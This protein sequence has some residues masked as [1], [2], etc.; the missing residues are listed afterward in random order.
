MGNVSD[1]G[2]S[3]EEQFSGGEVGHYNPEALLNDRASERV[4]E[5]YQR[6]LGFQARMVPLGTHK[7]AQ[8]NHWTFIQNTETCC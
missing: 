7:S 8:V 6:V 1:E 3:T 2:G 4:E 5:R